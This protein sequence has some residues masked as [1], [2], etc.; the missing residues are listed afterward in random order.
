[1]EGNGVVTV[2]L[3]VGRLYLNV[4]LPAFFRLS[5]MIRMYTGMCFKE[6]FHA[7]EHFLALGKQLIQVPVNDWKGAPG[8]KEILFA[9]FLE[10]NVTSFQKFK[11]VSLICLE[12]ELGHGDRPPF[13]SKSDICSKVPGNRTFSAHLSS[14]A[15][16]TATE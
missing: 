15:A 1:M 8:A 13:G 14:P 9:C 11:T 4:L 5:L 3:L 6:F 10:S 12:V 7:L 16:A 2:L